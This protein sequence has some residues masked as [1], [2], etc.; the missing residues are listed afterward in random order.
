[1]L[2]R[3]KGRRIQS[4]GFAQPYYYYLRLRET[5]Q[6]LCSG[7]SGDPATPATARSESGSTLGSQKVLGRS[8]Y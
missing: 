8:T 7:R 4:F 1:M 3:V 2:G 5:R 6:L